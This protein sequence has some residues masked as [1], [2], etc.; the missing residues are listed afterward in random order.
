MKASYL[1]LQPPCARK[2]T[3]PCHTTLGTTR[4]FRKY[5]IH[6]K[7]KAEIQ[8]VCNTRKWPP[9]PV[10]NAVSKQRS[11]QNRAIFCS[12]SKEGRDIVAEY[13]RH[14]RRRPQNRALA[15][16]RRRGPVLRHARF[17]RRRRPVP[18]IPSGRRIASGAHRL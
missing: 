5:P 4:A 14:V 8:F 10:S 16:Q 9:R 3:S 11:R 15:R 2:H 18:A 6:A 13:A 12:Y 17:P 1:A 7:N